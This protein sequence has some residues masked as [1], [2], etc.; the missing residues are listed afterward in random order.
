MEEAFCDTLKS[1]F[2]F[3]SGFYDAKSAEM[4]KRR[5]FFQTKCQLADLGHQKFLIHQYYDM[6]D[7]PNPGEYVELDKMPD[8]NK[9]PVKMV[10]FNQTYI[11]TQDFVVD[12]SHEYLNGIILEN[13]VL[14]QYRGDNFEQTIHKNIED[15]YRF[16]LNKDLV[17][18]LFEH[19]HDF[20]IGK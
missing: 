8:Q 4:R 13:Q 12:F 15:F 14:L 11:A 2:R 10:T 19:R 17:R 6:N 20:I 16:S 9:T 7:I 1:G 5:N 18:A 3:D